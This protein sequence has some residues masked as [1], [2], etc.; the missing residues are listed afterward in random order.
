MIELRYYELAAKRR[1][2]RLA[3]ENGNNGISWEQYRQMV[4]AERR[5]I[6]QWQRYCKL[7]GIIFSF[8]NYTALVYSQYP[9]HRPDSAVRS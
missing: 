8:V 4:F 5:A 6:Q 3:A 9:L 7:H 1:N 2:E